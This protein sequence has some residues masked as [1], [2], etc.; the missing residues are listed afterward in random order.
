MVEKAIVAPPRYAASKDI[1]PAGVK[2]KPRNAVGV[3]M[4][5]NYFCAN[6]N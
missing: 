1:V 6:R 2:W 3:H 4:R 5:P